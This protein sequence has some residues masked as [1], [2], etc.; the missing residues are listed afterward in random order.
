MPFD[1]SGLP[2]LP[3]CES[4]IARWAG[5]LQTWLVSK[6]SVAHGEID[7]VVVDPFDICAELGNLSA[8]TCLV[9]ATG[10]DTSAFV[11][12]GD[13]DPVVPG[14]LPWPGDALGDLMSGT[15]TMTYVR[16]GVVAERV[17]GVWQDFVV[18]FTTPLPTD[19]FLLCIEP[20]TLAR[21]L[22]WAVGFRSTTGFKIHA[23]MNTNV[24]VDATWVYTA[25]AFQE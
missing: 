15:V 10:I 18:N 22:F 13:G 23:V 12:A 1:P 6:L 4:D 11:Y 25:I 19:K 5:D 24:D 14:T 2:T 7:N 17:T 8:P 20:N 21:D 9:P 16:Q 3:T